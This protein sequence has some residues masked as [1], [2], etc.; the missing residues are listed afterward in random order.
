M[1]LNL[2]GRDELGHTVYTIAN[3]LM[4]SNIRNHTYNL[5][6]PYTLN[7]LD[8][9]T[10]NTLGFKYYARGSEAYQEMINS[11]HKISVTGV[12]SSI[13]FDYSFNLKAV[14]CSPGY[15]FKYTSCV[16]NTD[17]SGVLR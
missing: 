17:I 3:V 10:N 15:V 4:T 7:V 9:S 16:C 13:N 11:S 12:Y 5:T 8:S 1:K 2:Q 14:A 6:V